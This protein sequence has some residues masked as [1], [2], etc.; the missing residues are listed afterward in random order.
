MVGI[1]GAMALEVEKLLSL[2]AGREA[3]A[4]G[5]TQFHTGK[6]YGQDVVLAACGVGKVNAALC[7]QAMLLHFRPS[8]IL[9]VGVAG[10]LLPEMRIGD[11]A[12][13]SS[14]VQHDM[15]TT[16][17][18]DPRG[19]ISNLQCVEIPCSAP[20]VSTLLAAAEHLEG[21]HVHTGV[22]ATGDQFIAKPEVKA[23]LVR[24]FNAIA[25]EMEGAAIGQACALHG[26][27]F[28]VVRAISDGADA[29]AAMDFPA[30]ARAAA[31]RSAA[32][33]EHALAEG[34]VDTSTKEQ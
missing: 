11:I 33:L 17:L 2:L 14:V 19:Y 8:M 27:P 26:V 16:P 3:R 18:G 9:N 34:G 31:E 5:C 4:V 12:V 7:A 22:V 25:C 23:D 30:F 24:Q 10:G 6:L 21:V 29:G 20:L 1:I 32:L 28:A 15:D 13:A